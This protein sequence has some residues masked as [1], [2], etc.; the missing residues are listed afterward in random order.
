[1]QSGGIFSLQTLVSYSVPIINI[2]FRITNLWLH[3]ILSL[4]MLSWF[5]YLKFFT[6]IF[7]FQLFGRYLSSVGKLP[8]CI[9]RIILLAYH[10]NM[11]WCNIASF[12][13]PFLCIYSISCC[14]KLMLVFC[15]G[16]FYDGTVS[17]GSVL[18]SHMVWSNHS[19]MSILSNA[20]QKK[21]HACK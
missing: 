1:M 12:H 16:L 9:T 5:Y 14:N 10:D 17:N 6:T 8:P 11:I 20:L 7:F 13:A 19:R 18:R 4:F 3:V 21:W 15:S 2:F